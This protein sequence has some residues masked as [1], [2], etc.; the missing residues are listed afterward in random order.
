LAKLL[1]SLL[2]LV[3]LLL[4]KFLPLLAV[5]GVS[6]AFLTAFHVDIPEVL[7][8]L[9]LLMSFLLMVF[10]TFL[11][12]CCCWRPVPAIVGLFAVICVSAIVGAPAVVGAIYCG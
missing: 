4:S 1:P 3:P 8:S 5:A 6:A 11:M 10:P 7:K 2:L 9:L 12:F